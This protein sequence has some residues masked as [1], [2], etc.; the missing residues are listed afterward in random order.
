MHS[1][2]S[3]ARRFHVA[4]LLASV[5]AAVSAMLSAGCAPVRM[6]FEP[7][8]ISCRQA[9]AALGPAVRW[10]APADAGDRKKLRSWCDAVGPIAMQV[11]VQDPGDRADH[12][13]RA[14]VVVSWNMAVGKGDLLRLLEEVRGGHPDAEVI[15]LLQEAYRAATVP[16][17]CPPG[18]ARAR[19]LGLPRSPGS[20]DIV[21]L[22][23]RAGMHYVY[24][25][26]MRNGV[27]CAA[28]PREDRG[29]AILSTLPL[30]D[31]AVVELPFA[32]QR[33]VALAARARHGGRALGVMSTHFDTL[34]GHKR[35]A[36]AIAQA[37]GLL[38]WS[39]PIVVGGDFNSALV[40]DSGMREM[41]KHFV[42]LDCGTRPTHAVL[43]RLDHVFIGPGDA[44]VSCQTG[45]GRHG[46]DHSPLIAGP[47]PIGEPSPRQ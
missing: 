8:L 32:Q 22:A 43:G 40:L 28:G 17:E 39:G 6:Q 44:P 12:P 7:E 33:R 42:E 16:A 19:A 30:S 15:L 21:D 47:W 45:D 46:S 10:L 38:G 35:M 36:R 14:L 41:R 1:L 25:P 34:R 18:S 13:G 24:A 11:G 23:E 5:C 29:N 3:V 2:T 27:D 4:P 31:V 20:E 26:S 9:D 37:V